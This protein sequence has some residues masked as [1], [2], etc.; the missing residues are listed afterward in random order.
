MAMF[1]RREE[2]RGS[3]IARA[4]N[5]I[6]QRGP[7]GGELLE[8][9]S[10]KF[11]DGCLAEVFYF[12]IETMDSSDVELWVVVT[13]ELTPG[14]PFSGINIIYVN[15]DCSLNIWEAAY[16]NRDVSAQT[17]V[18]GINTCAEEGCHYPHEARGLCKGHYR[19]Y[20][21]YRRETNAILAAEGIPYSDRAIN[22]S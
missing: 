3:R 20:R 7:I 18:P 8:V 9:D 12:A 13:L 5:E 10:C 15:P 19:E 16:K 4:A 1:T 2:E 21:R 11:P 14:N 17:L 22:H 6:L